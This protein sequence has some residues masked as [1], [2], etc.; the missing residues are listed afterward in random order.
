M[1]ELTLSKAKEILAKHT[2][3]AHLF[4]HAA[5]VSA[6]MGAMADHF[7]AD[8]EY[9]EAIGYLH[10]VDYEKFPDEHCHHVRELLEP[11][12]VGEEV[13]QTIISHGWGITTDEKEPVTD[14]EKSL[15]TVDELTGIVQAYALM[16]PEKM[17]GMEL[18]S[19]KKKFK[20]KKF[21]A[22][23]SRDTIKKGMEMLGMEPS[24]VMQCCIDG[25]QAHKEELGF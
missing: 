17:D 8:K 6:A 5:A 9:W 1:S 23:C 16:R 3:E 19:F 13:I 24:E 22:K 7:G 11:E 15:Y 4:T 25:M 21:A 20:D 10:D 18:K 14:I 12:G 2:T